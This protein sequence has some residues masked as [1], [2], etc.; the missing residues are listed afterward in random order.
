MKCLE[1]Y[2][3]IKNNNIRIKIEKDSIKYY[4]EDGEEINLTIKEEEEED[5]KKLKK[6]IS[7]LNV[8]LKKINNSNNKELIYNFI[9]NSVIYNEK[10]EEEKSITENNTEEKKMITFEYERLIDSLKEP[11]ENIDHILNIMSSEYRQNVLLIEKEFGDYNYN[12]KL[13]SNAI[14]EQKPNP[15]FNIKESDLVFPK[16]DTELI[17]QSYKDTFNN[18]INTILLSIDNI[19]KKGGSF[20]SDLYSYIFNIRDNKTLIEFATTIATNIKNITNSFSKILNNINTII[21]NVYRVNDI[22]SLNYKLDSIMNS[23]INDLNFNN[24]YRDIEEIISTYNNNDIHSLISEV[25]KIYDCIKLMK[26]LYDSLLSNDVLRKESEV[27]TKYEGTIVDAFTGVGKNK[28]ELLSRLENEVNS[29]Y[30]NIDQALLTNI[31]KMVTTIKNLEVNIEYYKRTENKNDLDIN[32]L[33]RIV[34]LSNFNYIFKDIGYLD[35]YGLTFDQT[36]ISQLNGLKI[37]LNQSMYKLKERNRKDLKEIHNKYK[38]FEEKFGGLKNLEK[39]M[40]LLFEKN[41]NIRTGYLIYKYDNSKLIKS[42]DDFRK[43]GLNIN[44]LNLYKE[45]NNTNYGEA[46]NHLKNNQEKGINYILGIEI[47]NNKNI[48]TSLQLRDYLYENYVLKYSSK[49]FVGA[50]NDYL[51]NNKVFKLI[52]PNLSIESY[53]DEIE[54]RID[55]YLDNMKNIVDIKG[56]RTFTNEYVDNL[57]EIYKNNVKTLRNRFR[58]T[59][60]VNKVEINNIKLGEYNMILNS[61]MDIMD[62]YDSYNVL[63]YMQDENEYISNLINNN[64][65]SNVEK[66]KIIYDKNRFEKIYKY[67]IGFSSNKLFYTDN[68]KNYSKEYEEYLKSHSDTSLLEELY[69]YI[70]NKLKELNNGLDILNQYSMYDGKLFMFQSKKSMQEILNEEGIENII[71]DNLYDYFHNTASNTHVFY[72][73]DTNFIVPFIRTTKLSITEDELSYNIFLNL[74]NATLEK[75][76]YEE[77]VELVGNAKSHIISLEQIS[78]NTGSNIIQL[79]KL[80]LKIK[81]KVET[82]LGIKKVN[83]FDKPVV[84]LNENGILKIKK[85]HAKDKYYLLKYNEFVDEINREIINEI[86]ANYFNVANDLRQKANIHINVSSKYDTPLTLHDI[87]R[88][89]KK[90]NEYYEKLKADGSKM[91]SYFETKNFYLRHFILHV[92]YGNNVLS[93]SFDNYL[94]T[95]KGRLPLDYILDMSS[96]EFTKLFIDFIEENI[97]FKYLYNEPQYSN[98]SRG[99]SSSDFFTRAYIKNTNTLVE[100][101]QID[102]I[103]PSD[104]RYKDIIDADKINMYF[105][106]A[107]IDTINKLTLNMMGNIKYT[108]SKELDKIIDMEKLRTIDNVKVMHVDKFLDNLNTTVSKTFLNF[109]PFTF[110]AEMSYGFFG[111]FNFALSS[112][113]YSFLDASISLMESISNI[114]SSLFVENKKLE[115]IK[116][117]V[118]REEFVNMISHDNEIMKTFNKN[119]TID[120][121]IKR[122]NDFISIAGSIPNKLYRETILRMISKK[123]YVKVNDGGQQKVINI[124]DCF[125]SDGNQIYQIDNIDLVR[126]LQTFEG[127]LKT[128]TLYNNDYIEVSRHSWMRTLLLF[129]TFMLNMFDEYFR[130]PVY[131]PYDNEYRRGLFKTLFGNGGVFINKNNKLRIINGILVFMKGLFG[132]QGDLKYRSDIDNIRKIGLQLLII[133]TLYLIASGIELELYEEKDDYITDDE[134][135]KIKVKRKVR[136][137]VKGNELRAL[138]SLVARVYRENIFMYSPNSTLNFL[139]NYGLPQVGY[140]VN[141][142]EMINHAL[143]QEVYTTGIYKGKYKWNIDLMQS[144][145]LLNAYLRFQ[146]IGNNAKLQY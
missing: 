36:N 123:F 121:L 72:L 31:S 1:I 134:G 2:V 46:F 113:N 41:N 111:L 8:K 76:K 71:R 90:V 61:F 13:I 79:N 81:N 145:Y 137:K 94:S 66:K 83:T 85:K 88:Y 53:L 44:L 74:I 28:M 114:G 5:I 132:Y 50:S 45:L 37:L 3:K 126:F 73:N 67:H 9:Y 48:N 32:D 21:S 43:T 116:E 119:D 25:Y 70:Y 47:K 122:Y 69:D 141:Y 139:G 140:V 112:K 33:K 77:S 108:E 100:D 65:Y 135:N 106:R 59:Y 117:L 125:D 23:E 103:Q 109:N 20:D 110:V 62:R 49:N 35:L 14:I 58:A 124:F 4:N 87:Y 40:K 115:A 64:T 39:S 107:T 12:N 118:S 98:I 80:P 120:N 18:A 30:S 19:N 91:T 7:D 27:I 78:V 84:N 99:I 22:I 63:N 102:Y 95:K 131:I 57:R 52:N 75:N 105:T 10:Y 133:T 101:Y 56:N 51:S 146:N 104:K 15:L 82:E 24:I 26:S 29:S 129:K 127:I 17:Y 34:G 42:E 128:V 89:F 55:I 68:N 142:I 97:E 96:I 138:Y 54:K 86:S 130:E 11:I 38:Y 92:I 136:N 60:D 6:L 144:N 93:S 143:N 16:K